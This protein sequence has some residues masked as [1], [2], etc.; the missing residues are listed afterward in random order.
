MISFHL[1]NFLHFKGHFGLC[2]F[3][4]LLPIYNRSL[5]RNINIYGQHLF[6][7]HKRKITRYGDKYKNTDLLF[8]RYIDFIL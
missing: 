5:D 6:L 1:K 3:V 4:G 8:V 2:L 7:K